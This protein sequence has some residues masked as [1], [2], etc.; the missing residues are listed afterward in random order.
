ML[1][2]LANT[3]LFGHLREQPPPKDAVDQKV[4]LPS[5]ETIALIG[6]QHIGAAALGE[7]SC[8]R[9]NDDDIFSPEMKLKEFASGRIIGWTRTEC[10]SLQEAGIIE[11][12]AKG[13]DQRRQR[14]GR[15]V[16]WER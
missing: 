8:S 1:D 5:I 7:R 11:K 14:Q 6:E 16:R 15:E 10:N 2:S 12:G 4:H 3:V 9:W 13:R